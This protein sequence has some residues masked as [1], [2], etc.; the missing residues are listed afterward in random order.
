M[1]IK[2]IPKVETLVC[3]RCKAESNGKG[4]AGDPFYFGEMNMRCEDRITNYMGDS[5]G[6]VSRYDLC[7]QCMQD[8][9]KWMQNR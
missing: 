3:D 8:F 2:V 4:I 6:G 9:K 7:Y 1:S 5:A